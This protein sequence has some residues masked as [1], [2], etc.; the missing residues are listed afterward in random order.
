[1]IQ[2]T[3]RVWLSDSPSESAHLPVHTY[4]PFFLNKC[5]TCFTTF[6]LCGNSFLQSWRAQ[7]LVNDHQYSGYDL[8]L[9][10]LH[11]SLNLW[12]GTQAPLQVVAIWGHP[13]SVSGQSFW[14]TNLMWLAHTSLNQDVQEG[15]WEFHRTHGLVSPL[16]FWPFRDSSGWW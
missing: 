11:P 8:I 14:L 4:C 10:M 9:S 12:L 15:F 1:M 16:S 3:T 2:T 13:R 5:S 6:H 7:A